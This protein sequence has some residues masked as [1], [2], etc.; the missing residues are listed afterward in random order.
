MDLELQDKEVALQQAEVEKS[1][2]NQQL[3]LTRQETEQQINQGRKV[4]RRTATFAACAIG[5]GVLAFGVAVQQ[6]L[7]AADATRTADQAKQ[8]VVDAEQQ[9]EAI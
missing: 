1:K 7:K 5:A 4:Q 9:I 6:G 2:A 8:Q 3:A